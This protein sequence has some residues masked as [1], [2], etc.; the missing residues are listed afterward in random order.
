MLAT[1]TETF[2]NLIGDLIEA[3]RSGDAERDAVA[4]LAGHHETLTTALT[5]LE[6][7]HLDDLRKTQAA[8]N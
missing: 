2:A 8:W 3:V 7:R 5:V 1:L 4:A 6:T